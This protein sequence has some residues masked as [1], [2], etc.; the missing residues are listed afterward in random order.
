MRV[1]AFLCVYLYI[2]L[3]V[4]AR[5]QQSKVKKPSAKRKIVS[6]PPPPPPAEKPLYKEPGFWG[7]GL[8]S[9][10]LVSTVATAMHNKEMKHTMKTYSQALEDKEKEIQLLKNVM[11]EKRERYLKALQEHKKNA[12][13]LRSQLESSQRS[14]AHHSSLL[15]RVKKELLEVKNDYTS[16]KQSADKALAEM[17]RFFE[18]SNK[19][20]KELAIKNAQ[21]LQM[22]RQSSILNQQ[23]EAQVV[24]WRKEAQANEIKYE[25]NWREAMKVIIEDK[26]ANPPPAAMGDTIARIENLE[27]QAFLLRNTFTKS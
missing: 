24:H 22:V 27:R 9:G 5:Q 6:P 15:W 17:T 13:D 1:S 18:E 8:A 25:K 16:N 26:K 12:Q 4:E 14:A 7:L 2:L 10:T 23:L 20:R 3:T 21:T 19:E 11:Q